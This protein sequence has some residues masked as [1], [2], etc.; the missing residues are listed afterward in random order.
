MTNDTFT[1][2][3]IIQLMETWKRQEHTPA[4]TLKLL[5][6]YLGVSKW[7]T[8]EGIYPSAFFYD[9]SKQFHTRSTTEFVKKIIAA[10]GFGYIWDSEEHTP[11]H[12]MG[13]FSP[14]RYHPS[15]S[16]SESGAGNIYNINNI[17]PDNIY[18]SKNDNIYHIID[19]KSESGASRAAARVTQAT[20][21]DH[22]AALAVEGFIQR[23]CTD[24][25]DYKTFIHPINLRTEQ[26]MPELHVDATTSNARP[27]NIATRRY[28]THYLGE[29]FKA[30]GKNFINRTYEGRKI[31]LSRVMAKAPAQ[32]NIVRA[33]S[34]IKSQEG[35]GSDQLRRQ[36]RPLSPH[37]YQDRASG[38]RFYD[39]PSAQGTPQPV[40]IPQDAPP[41]PS[42]SA[43]WDKLMKQ[44]SRE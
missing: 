26:L 36:C 33:V 17:N 28:L 29:Y 19:S 16:K 10:E 27:V 22:D 5:K 40:R 8:Q 32:H 38:Q 44:W 7:M 35:N 12:L 14:I 24:E 31:W 39:S 37:E 30:Q 3:T 34:D 6:L 2:D 42:D 20:E 15:H 1:P 25:A 43:R 9:M 18:I 23:L 11:Q 41:R 21:T 13:F 4:Q